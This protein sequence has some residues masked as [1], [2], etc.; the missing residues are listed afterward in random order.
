MCD[1]VCRC[2]QMTA[3]VS[4]EGVVDI[5]ESAGAAIMRVFDQEVSGV[6]P[7]KTPA[8]L[9]GGVLVCSTVLGANA[10]QDGQHFLTTMLQEAHG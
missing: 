5:A 2:S 10:E 1:A 3:D 7:W 9:G 4:V 8:G 6:G